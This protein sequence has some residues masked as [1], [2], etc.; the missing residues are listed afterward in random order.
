MMMDIFSTF[1]PF[2]YYSFY[3]FSP[4]FWAMSLL[5]LIFLSSSYWMTPPSYFW[6]P[7]SVLSMG[8]DQ[9]KRTFSIHL[10]SLASIL[11]P[12]FLMIITMNL[13]GMIPYTLSASSH[14][15][16]SVTLALPLWLSLILSGFT[17][18]PKA[19]TANFLPSGAPAWLAPALILIETISVMVRPIT[20]SVRLAAN[21]SAG[22]I[23][24]GL[25]GIYCATAFANSPLSMTLLLLIQSGYTVFELGICCI[26]A[27][28][29]FLLLTLYADEHPPL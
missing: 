22:H 29:F 14:L 21:M 6:L 8:Y 27:Y 9:V 13:I 1:D 7:Q 23:V 20:L 17:K 10:K 24:L 26:Q 28:I 2:N 19:A 3:K 16:F 12:L 18:K 11:C 4:L 5:P 15:L 25:M